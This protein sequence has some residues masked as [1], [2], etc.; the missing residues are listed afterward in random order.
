MKKKTQKRHREIVFRKGKPS[1]I[2]LGIKE[3][4]EMLERLEDTESLKLL[5]E[6]TTIT[7]KPDKSKK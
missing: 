7:K 1:A 4:G 6:A 5:E 2:I 3:Y